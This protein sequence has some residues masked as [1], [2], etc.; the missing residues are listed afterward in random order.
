MITD[1]TLAHLRTSASLLLVTP[2]LALSVDVDGR[3]IVRAHRSPFADDENA[4]PVCAFHRCVGR[5]HG[6]RRA[7]SQ[8][9]MV[10]LPGDLEPTVVLEGSRDVQVLPGG[11]VRR[12]SDGSWLHLNALSLPAEAVEQIA[13][14]A[15]E[16]AGVSMSLHSDRVLDVTVLVTDTPAGD[17]AAAAEAIDVLEH[18]AA[19][20]TVESLVAMLDTP[21]DWSIAV[22]ESGEMAHPLD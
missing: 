7:G 3:Q 15:T 14:E 1:R 12:S 11:M 5:A 9:E 10:G 19:V 6:L 17:R 21:T 22:L 4:I 13:A 20:A 2:G 8:V 18:V 16:R